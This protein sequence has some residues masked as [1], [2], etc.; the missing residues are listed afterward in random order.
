MVEI[1]DAIFTI[2]EAEHPATVRQ[3]YYRLVSAGV[4]EKTEA[5]YK[6]TVCRLLVDMREDG[7]LPYSWLA[8]STRWMR[9]PTTYA[10]L[11]DAVRLTAETY[12]R[13]LWATLDTYVEVWLEKDALAGV[14]YDVTHE[15]DVPLMVTRGYPSISYMHEAAAAIRMVNKPTFIYYFGDH[16]PSGVDIPVQVERRLRQY[17]PEAEIHFERVAVTRDQ[18]DEW[19]LPTR[20]TKATDTRAKRFDGESVEVDAIA[21]DELRGIAR[22]CIRDHVDLR[23][24]EVLEVAEASER[25]IL[26]QFANTLRPA[27]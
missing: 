20:P 24:L 25:E 16:D 26:S 27:S 23:R 18:I 8:D 22:R 2:L 14:L 4:I 21:P 15:W 7:T 19:D 11:A 13:A 10:S 17:A 1:R 5:E 3:V 6:A 12:R 9:K